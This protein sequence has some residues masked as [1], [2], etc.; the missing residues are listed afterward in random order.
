[1]ALGA[2]DYLTK[3]FTI[4]ELVGAVNA[5]LSKRARI[6]QESEEK[7][8]ELRAQLSASLPHE[9]RTPIA[10]IIGYAEMLPDRVHSGSPEEVNELAR[11]I[12]DAG[13]RMNR[14]TENSLLY[15]QLELLRTR[16][17]HPPESSASPVPLHAIAERMG[18]NKAIVHGRELDLVLEIA[19]ATTSACESYVA[20]LAGELI[21]NA[22]KFSRRGTPVRVRT[23]TTDRGVL[24]EVADQGGGMSPD[25]VAAIGAFVKFE[26]MQREQ[27]GLGLGLTIAHRIAAVLGG[28]LSI[29]SEP[30]HG[31]TVSVTLPRAAAASAAGDRASGG[32]AAAS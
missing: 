9:L 24:F 25:Q 29:A 15:M 4:D 5:A 31:T 26:R 19:D 21:D 18:R 22:F 1:M 16:R 32:G 6:E 12:L 20:R 10:C 17:D 30:G 11:G 27:D 23:A 13:M 14:I 28:D 7:L 3:P 2:D 8:S